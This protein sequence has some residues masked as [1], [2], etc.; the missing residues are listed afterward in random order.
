M[1]TTPEDLANHHIENTQK[2]LRHPDVVAGLGRDAAHRLIGLADTLY[3]PTLTADRHV[4]FNPD[5]VPL[6][7]VNPG[8]SVTLSGDFSGFTAEQYASLNR[9]GVP[10]EV[11]NKMSGALRPERTVAMSEESG[12]K[13]L[14]RTG[15]YTSASE[16]DF[17]LRAAPLI[18]ISSDLDDRPGYD[19][20]AAHEIVHADQ[21]LRSPYQIRHPHPK[22]ASEVKAYDVQAKI[23]AAFHGENANT[24]AQK[25]SSYLKQWRET[26]RDINTPKDRIEFEKWLREHNAGMLSPKIKSKN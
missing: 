3:V 18:A 11:Q 25:V 16:K 26:G 17:I 8:D 2:Q 13:T 23:D 5:G 4:R 7:V 19:S 6:V 12:G 21:I 10:L 14:Y 24:R 22:V 9:K 20:I 1:P 15:S